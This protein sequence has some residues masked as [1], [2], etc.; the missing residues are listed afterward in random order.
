MDA[1]VD[2]AKRLLDYG[3]G[4]I[5]MFTMAPET[6]RNFE[7]IDFLSNQNIVVFAGHSDATFDCLNQAIGHGLKGFTH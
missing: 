7:T 6:D 2:I 4:N 3:G 5:Q 1:Q